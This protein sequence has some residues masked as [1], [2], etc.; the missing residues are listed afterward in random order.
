MKIKTG[1][2]DPREGDRKLKWPFSVKTAESQN[3]AAC[4]K[5]NF[6][7][8]RTL[9]CGKNCCFKLEIPLFLFRVFFGGWGK[10]SSCSQLSVFPLGVSRQEKFW[11]GLQLLASA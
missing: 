11:G 9:Y 1:K 8:Q 7:K 6:K 4:L 2:F 5:I 3:L 10:S